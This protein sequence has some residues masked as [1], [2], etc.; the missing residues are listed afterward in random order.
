MSPHTSWILVHE[1]VPRLAA[2]IPRAVKMVGC[3]DV[4]ELIQDATALAA[5]MLNNTE[6]AG[7]Q[8]TAGNIAY[9]TLQH[10]K[11]GRRSVGHS[12]ADVLGTATQLNGRSRVSS[13]DEPVAME[14]DPCSEFTVNDVF[15]SDQEDPSTAAARKMDWDEFMKH[16]DDCCKAIV[17]A[18]V[19]GES[20]RPLSVRF[21]L[22]A[23]TIQN[24]KRQL[25]LRILQFMGDAVLVDSTRQPQWRDGIVALRE[26]QAC[27]LE[28]AVGLLS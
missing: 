17:L 24:R 16:Q 25:G 5:R 8:V 23:S 21:K 7:K 22:S 14:D 15:G 18:L 10:V 28:R 1:V 4:E 12:N 26:K 2:S 13:F 27:R 20:V 19:E 11:S 6:K 3:E 9:Y